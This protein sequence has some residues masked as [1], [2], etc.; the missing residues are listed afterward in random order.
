M[1]FKILFEFIRIVLSQKGLLVI[2]KSKVFLQKYCISLVPLV[3]VH[4]H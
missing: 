4:V 2:S 3:D 1:N